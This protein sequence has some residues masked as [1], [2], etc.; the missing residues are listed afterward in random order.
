MRPV[1]FSEVGGYHPND[2]R[3]VFQGAFEFWFRNYQKVNSYQNTVWVACGGVLGA[4]ARNGV[5]LLL[6][7]AHVVHPAFPW[8]TFFINVSGSAMLGFLM[9]W[10]EESEKHPRWLQPLDG[11]GFCGAF[12]TF[13]T[14]S[15]EILLLA[16]DGQPGLAMGYLGVSLVSAVLA[17]TVATAIATRIF[18]KTGSV[19][20]KMMA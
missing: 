10:V 11:I 16:R 15:V 5:D 6:V 13:S 14:T 1:D 7:P 3:N 17:V 18:I 19:K 12:T 2:E 20:G 9:A 4:L 8:S